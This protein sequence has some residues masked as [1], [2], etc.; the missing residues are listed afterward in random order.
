MLFNG[1]F[2]RPVELALSCAW[3]IFVKYEKQQL[4]KSKKQI[5]EYL[6]F[7]AGHPQ[8]TT[9]CL[10]KVSDTELQRI[11]VLIGYSIPHSDR[12]DQRLKYSAAMIALF[13]PWTKNIDS[14]LKAKDEDWCTV[15]QTL[16]SQLPPNH[17]K[18]I[19]NMQLLYQSRDAKDAYSAKRR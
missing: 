2:Y 11:P 12:E 13:K 1:I 15:Y 19:E 9:H 8:Y 14:P 17:C 7:A 4:P 10:K 18:I 5:K 3:D 16:Q 6:R